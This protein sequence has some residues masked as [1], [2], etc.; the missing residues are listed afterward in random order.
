ML[1]LVLTSAVA[2]AF[3]DKPPAKNEVLLQ[4][5]RIKL[6]DQLTL[7][8]DRNGVVAD[9]PFREGESVTARQRVASLRD[10][11]ARAQLA[12]AQAKAEY[13]AEIS[14]KEKAYAIAL[15]EH[16]QALEANRETARTVPILEVERL[17]LAAEQASFEIEE[18]KQKLLIS[19]L[20][21]DQMQAELSTYAIVAPINGVVT[22]VFKKRGE[23]VRQGDPVLELTS[24]ERVRVDGQLSL[25]DAYR[26]KQGAKVFVQL[27]VADHDLPGEDRVFEGRVTFVNVEVAQSLK[28]VKVSADVVNPDNVLRAGLTA[29]MRILVANDSPGPV[30]QSLDSQQRTR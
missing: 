8:A 2:F 18:A 17:R 9:A 11:V 14:A 3:G 10:E 5:C 23:A 20:E 21:R 13:T 22:N 27:D 7:A 30:T 6:I 24:T 4:D 19:K 28:T 16:R 29:R 15:N 1:S 26:V 25:A 12:V